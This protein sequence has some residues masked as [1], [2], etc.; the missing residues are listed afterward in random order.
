MENKIYSAINRLIKINR[1]HKHLIDSKVNEIGIHRTG[2]RILML[3][4]RKGNLPSQK[5]LAL[6]LDVTPAAVT[7][8]VQRLEKDGYIE[9]KMGNDNRFNELYVTK[10]GTEIVE[11]TRE[12]FKTVDDSLFVGFSDG[13]IEEFCGYLDRIIFNMKGASC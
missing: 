1:C 10:K 13:E 4:A 6:H 8:A 3:L 5:E 9:R 7:L 2:H 11:T 12:K